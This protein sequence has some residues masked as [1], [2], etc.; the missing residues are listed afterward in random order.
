MANPFFWAQSAP[1]TSLTAANLELQR[2][3]AGESVLVNGWWRGVDAAG[4]PAWWDY[5]ITGGGAIATSTTAGE[6]ETCG[7]ALELSG[8]TVEAYQDSYGL[9][10]EGWRNREAVLAIHG[11]STVA[12]WS[13]LI[14]F[15]AG[16][17]SATLTGTIGGGFATQRL[18][19]AV[20][21]GADKMLVVLRW[22]S[23]TGKALIDRVQLTPGPTQ[24]AWLSDSLRPVVLAE[25]VVSD[26]AATWR[27]EDAFRLAAWNTNATSPTGLASVTIT[28]AWTG[29]SDYWPTGWARTGA[30][31]DYAACITSYAMDE[32]TGNYHRMVSPAASMAI[33]DGQPQ[34]T[35]TALTTTT[36]PSNDNIGVF[37][38]AWIVPR[39]PGPPVRRQYPFG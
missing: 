9:L 6:W 34:M 28:E 13:A 19:V 37:T 15:G 35:V 33:V 27:T 8:G 32:T 38:L 30:G 3:A 17:V 26:N 1:F 29:G 24:S 16:G 18:R 21:A 22:T 7:R 11:K 20:P 14:D 39:G 12:A 36:F 23:A 31:G 2:Q 5:Y 25:G 4:L 10:Q